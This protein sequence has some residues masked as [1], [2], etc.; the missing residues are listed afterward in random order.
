MNSKRFKTLLYNLLLAA[1]I[2]ASAISTA[3][4]L[5]LIEYQATGL[6]G[7]TNENEQLA[8]V[9]VGSAN[10]QIGGFGVYARARSDTNIG[11]VIFDTTDLLNPVYQSPVQSVGAALA[12][13]WYD[14]PAMNFTLLATHTYAMGVVANKI[15]GT[16][17][18]QWATGDF[19]FGGGNQTSNGLTLLDDT[20]G[21][22]P[23]YCNGG[24]G[25]CGSG[26]RT[27]TSFLTGSYPDVF[28]ETLSTRT[29]MSLHIQAVPEPAE[30][31]MLIAGLF[32]VG[33]IARRRNGML[34]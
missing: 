24:F 1:G 26:T 23:G 21:V 2:L 16:G 8:K 18:F 30:W 4:A 17:G 10:V 6:T 15:G 7:A 28:S 19:A 5:P 13:M 25:P 3:N 22:R 31:A 29:K 34:G 33:F 27:L 9:T 14:S 20:S 32:V 12:A 11:W